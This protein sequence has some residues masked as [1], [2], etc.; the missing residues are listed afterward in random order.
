MYLGSQGVRKLDVR[1]VENLDIPSKVL[2]L[3]QPDIAFDCSLAS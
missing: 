1:I 3:F 2:N